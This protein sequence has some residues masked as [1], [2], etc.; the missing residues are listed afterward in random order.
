LSL[1]LDAVSVSL[2][3]LYIEEIYKKVQRLNKFE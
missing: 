1:L 2:D 3:L